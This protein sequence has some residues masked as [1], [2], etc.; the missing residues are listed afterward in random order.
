MSSYLE[1]ET[2]PTPVLLPR[3]SHGQRGL[4]SIGSQIIRHDSVTSLY[5]VIIFYQVS[6]DSCFFYMYIF[7]IILVKLYSVS[8]MVI[9][10]YNKGIMLI[11]FYGFSS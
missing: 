7:H 1:K 2:Q 9:F 6:R 3:K 10:R 8:K 5:D 11:H 4:Q